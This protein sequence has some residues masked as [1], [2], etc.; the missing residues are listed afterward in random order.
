MVY[1]GHS[2]WHEKRGQSLA[3]MLIILTILI[4]L[5]SIFQPVWDLLNELSQ[6]YVSNYVDRIIFSTQNNLLEYILASL[7]LQSVNKDKNP[8]PDLLKAALNI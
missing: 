7:C 2:Y 4:F 6:K 8:E 1:S 3:V 5:N